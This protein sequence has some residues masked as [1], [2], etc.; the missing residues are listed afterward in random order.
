[1][2]RVIYT[3][4][5]MQNVVMLSV[6]VLSG[7]APKGWQ[8]YQKFL[9]TGSILSFN[10]FLKFLCGPKLKLTPFW[11]TFKTR[12]NLGFLSRSWRQ[13]VQKRNSYRLNEMVGFEPT[14]FNP[15]LLGAKG[16]TVVTTLSIK[17]FIITTFSIMTVSI[18]TFSIMTFSI[19]TFSIMTFSIM[20]SSIKT[21][22]ITTFSIMTFSIM[23]FSIMTFSIMTFNITTFSITTFS[24]MTFSIWHSALLQIKLSVQEDSAKYL[25]QWGSVTH[26]MAVPVPSKSCCVS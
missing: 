7:V 12:I 24:I 26:Q 16:R 8:F 25:V 21:F 9:K 2:V 1:M 11:F 13:D 17:T 23:I 18:M 14:T 22:S 4:V 6:I 15:V 10:F 19:M 20:T 5:I 3:V